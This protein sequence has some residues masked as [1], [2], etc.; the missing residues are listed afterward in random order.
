M[1][2]LSFVTDFVY[3]AAQIVADPVLPGRRV[4]FLSP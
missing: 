4:L 1:M 2:R 3:G